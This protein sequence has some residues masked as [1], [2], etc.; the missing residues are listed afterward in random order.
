MNCRRVLRRLSP[1]LDEML[2]RDEALSVS[3]HLEEC[4]NCEEEMVRLR[5]V[6]NRLG[7]LSEVSEPDYLKDLVELRLKQ[8]KKESWRTSLM[9]AFGYRW[10]RIR[11]TG[12]TW[13]V[14][15]LLG[16][17]VTAV[18][19]FAIYVA[20]SP[21][22]MDLPAQG[23]QRA[24]SPERSEQLRINLLKNLG[25]TPVEAARKPISPSEP[26]INDLYLLDFGQ[27]ASRKPTNDSFSVVAAVD[28]KGSAKIQ[29][30]IEYPLDSSL[31][32]SFSNM[33]LT[34]RCRPASYN[35]RAIDSHLVL[36]FSK[37]NV[38]D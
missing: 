33:I 37:I 24:G 19:F 23:I 29:N 7:S 30:V 11:T 18:F 4:K 2:E 1:Y 34:A 21:I 9:D 3:S 8:M 20:M 5:L 15:R 32:D 22:V 31:L 13:Y 35:G 6:R 27:S 36:S 12:T 26:G 38:N 17:A 14:T 16:T 10:S 28:Q 25:L